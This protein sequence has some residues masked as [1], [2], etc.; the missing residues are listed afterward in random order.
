MRAF[1]I[2]ELLAVIVILCVLTALAYPTIN[3]LEKNKKR[4]VYEKNI[5]QI[6]NDTLT[7]IRENNLEINNYN[8]N[9]ELLKNSYDDPFS[10]EKIKGCINIRK[11]GDEYNLEYRKNCD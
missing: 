10:E 8:L 9:I 6:K 7:W 4:I 3:A 5:E 2:V 1:T 11:F